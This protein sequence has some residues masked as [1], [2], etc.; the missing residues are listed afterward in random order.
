MKLLSLGIAAAVMLGA[1]YLAEHPG[2]LTVDALR[3]L[4]HQLVR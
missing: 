3:A 1:F 4:L 2:A